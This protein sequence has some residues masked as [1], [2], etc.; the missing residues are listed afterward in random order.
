VFVVLSWIFA[1]YSVNGELILLLE[2][3]EPSDEDYWKIFYVLE[4]NSKFT[5]EFVLDEEPIACITK[6][7]LIDAHFVVFV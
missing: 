7:T 4:R 2:T 1:I 3:S 6:T 5:G